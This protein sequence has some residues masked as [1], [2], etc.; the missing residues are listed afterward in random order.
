MTAARQSTQPATGMAADQVG[1]WSY[2]RCLRPRRRL[3]NG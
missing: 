2:R 1:Q 3:S